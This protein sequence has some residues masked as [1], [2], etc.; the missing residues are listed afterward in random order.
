LQGETPPAI[1]HLFVMV[2][3]WANLRTICIIAPREFAITAKPTLIVVRV[4]FNWN[5]KVIIRQTFKPFLCTRFNIFVYNGHI[6]QFLSVRNIDSCEIIISSYVAIV[7]KIRPA[8]QGRAC[9]L[10]WMK[11]IPTTVI[12]FGF[13]SNGRLLEVMGE[14]MERIRL[15]YPKEYA[16]IMRRLRE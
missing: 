4:D 14:H 2:T 5:A 13:A 9:L 8:N 3:I 10:A 16:A 15:I 7:K 1:F 11:T 12:V 6:H